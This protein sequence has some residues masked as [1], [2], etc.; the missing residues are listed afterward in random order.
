MVDENGNV[1]GN[2]TE[3]AKSGI[4]AVLVSRVGMASPGM[5]NEIIVKT[6]SQLQSTTCYHLGRRWFGAM[7]MVNVTQGA[8]L[9]VALFWGCNHCVGL[10]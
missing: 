1:L 8:V 3:A 2:S 4:L 5:G 9:A 7:V 10:L 6:H